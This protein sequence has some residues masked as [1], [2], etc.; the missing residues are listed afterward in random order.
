[1][2]YQVM[3]KSLQERLDRTTKQ[4]EREQLEFQIVLLLGIIDMQ[5]G[6][7]KI[8]HAIEQLHTGE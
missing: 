2:P 7:T 1:M 8:V 3:L 6:V 4:R 5:K